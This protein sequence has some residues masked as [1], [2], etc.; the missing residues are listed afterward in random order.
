[1]GSRNLSIA[2]KPGINASL[3]QES[4]KTLG[5]TGD[6][7]AQ[8]GRVLTLISASLPLNFGLLVILIEHRSGILESLPNFG[9]FLGAITKIQAIWG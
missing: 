1:M 3:S 2:I 5:I 9:N 8:I 4:L 7:P 6:Q